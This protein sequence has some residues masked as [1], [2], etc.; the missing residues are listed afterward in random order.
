MKLLADWWRAL[1]GSWQLYLVALV[2]AVLATWGIQ[3]I[4]V[5]RAN[6]QFQERIN[7]LADQLSNGSAKLQTLGAVVTLG[8]LDAT[9]RGT[10]D[11]TL[12]PDNPE[13]LEK[14][15][16]LYARFHL[17]NALILNPDGVVVA[18]YIVGGKSG[19]GREL[20]YRPYFRQAITGV[21]NMYAALGTNT[22]ERGIYI[23]API[24]DQDTAANVQPLRVF[25]AMVAKLDFEEVDALLAAETDPLLVVSPEG[26]VFASNVPD[27]RFRVVGNAQTITQVMQDSRIG[28]AFDKTPPQ[29]LPLQPNG[30]ISYQG[31]RL[32][33]AAANVNWS[34]PHGDWR[35]LGFA[36]PMR[37]YSPLSRFLT[38]LVL[39][40]VVALAG[41]W[42]SARAQARARARQVRSLLD[43]SGQGFL[44]FGADLRFGSEYSQACEA[45]LGQSPA[46]ALAPQLLFGA[47]PGRAELFAMTI[48]AA[49]S[50]AD[51]QARESMLSLLPSELSRP[52]YLLRAEYKGLDNGRYMLVLTDVSEE[53]RMSALLESERRRMELI[54]QAITDSRN[55]FDTLDSLHA[56]L[57]LGLTQLLA[58]AQSPQTKARELYRQIHT[59]KGLLNQFC[60]TGTPLVLHALESQLSALIASGDSLSLDALAGLIDVPALRAAL[61]AELGLLREAL[62]EEFLA[63]GDSV[64]L[65]EEQ[66]RQLEQLALQLLR[67]EPVDTSVAEIRSLLQE[68]S[69]LRRVLFK[70]VLLGFNG[71]VRKTAERLH[72]QVAPLQVHSA[73]AVWIDPQAWRP[74]L[75]AL[76]HVFT[77]AV[78]H[79]IELPEERWEREKDETGTIICTV[80]QDANT[81]L[82]EIADD[83]AGLALQRLRQRAVEVGIC[84][85]LEAQALSDQ[86]AAQLIFRDQLSTRDAVD[87][88]AGRGVGL[89]VVWHETLRL[90]G[91]LWVHSMAGQGTT[92]HFEFPHLPEAV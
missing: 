33:L 65:S 13:V 27:W 64:V 43:N 20:G 54:V 26:A 7:R 15:A 81:I 60:F 32:H 39:F 12:A 1:R 8:S 41:H 28:T 88:L 38:A 62:G 78:A 68:V 51:P 11:G 35:L 74:L 30:T 79:G 46:G 6:G 5:V 59:F 70:D 17:S 85:T 63:R 3:E 29:L 16:K 61:E 40:G 44:T 14:L 45:M 57:D 76:V 2:L 86:E 58:N 48:E 4:F 75:R 55:F 47:D 10:A 69:A 49:A 25:G 34:D 9:V 22:G 50:E 24:L 90:G 73:E 84:S 42:R 89:A 87:A 31:Q 56:F 71:V 91:R 83:G 72:K 67:G 37:N 19:T 36:A 52:P 66:A 21:P 92:F 77:N 80:R 82:L 23:A 18:Y 53:R